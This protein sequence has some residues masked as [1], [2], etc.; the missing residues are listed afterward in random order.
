MKC[1]TLVRGVMLA[2]AV[3]LSGVLAAQ[4]ARKPLVVDTTPAAQPAAA[5]SQTKEVK[6]APAVKSKPLSENVTRGLKWLVEHQLKNGSWGQGEESVAM[7]GGAA[8]KDIPSVADTSMAALALVRAGNTPAKGP[9]AKNVRDAVNYVCGM[10]E[11]SG[12]DT[13][14][15]TTTRGTR[16]QVKLGPFIDT[17]AAS[18]LLAEVDN[19]MPDAAGQQRV[20]A[21]LNKLLVKIQKNQRPDGTWGGQGWATTLQQGMAVKGLNYMS[22]SGKPVDEAVRTKAEEQAR[23]SFDKG[24]GKFEKKDAAGVELY[25]AGTGLNS[26]T[27]SG[28]TNKQQTDALQKQAKDTSQPAAAQA[29]ASAKLQTFAAAQQDQA[30]AEQAVIARL[31]DKQ[32][33]AGF[34]SN[35]GEEFLSYLN[36]GE[37]LVVKGDKTWKSWDKSITENLLRVQNSDGSWSGHHCITGRTFCTA[38]ALLVLMVDRSLLPISEKMKRR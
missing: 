3:G 26:M 10:V 4:E 29:Y 14:E 28:I 5:N 7:G 38:A 20:S 31:D 23:K 24:S 17:F 16:V 36:I 12:K 35:G 18:L 22:Q 21:A 9:Y 11:E 34:G 37:S 1:R 33:I 15:V 6:W 32:F 8:M 27:Q 13:L 2:C 19:Q 30:A 25:A